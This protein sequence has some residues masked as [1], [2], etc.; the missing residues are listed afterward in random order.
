MKLTYATVGGGLMVKIVCQQCE[1]KLTC[2]RRVLD[3][4]SL[5]LFAHGVYYY[6]ILNYANPLA[7]QNTIW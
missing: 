3:T 2:G 7:L 6:L 1:T 4:A 5:A